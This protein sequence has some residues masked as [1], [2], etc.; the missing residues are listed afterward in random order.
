MTTRKLA[1]AE[2]RQPSR[3]AGAG[4]VAAP[5]HSL[6]RLLRLQRTVGNAAVAGLVAVQRGCGCGCG[7]VGGCTGPTTRRRRTAI[8]GCSG[9]RRTS[10]SRRPRVGPPPRRRHRCCRRGRTARRCA[11]C[12]STSTHL[13][14]TP[15]LEPDGAFGSLTQT[16]VKTFQSAHRLVPDGIV[17]P[18]T[19][20]MVRNERETEPVNFLVPCHTPE[21]P[22]PSGPKR[23]AGKEG[24]D[25]P[26]GGNLFGN[27][28]GREGEPDARA[29]RVPAGR[30]RG[31]SRRGQGPEGGLHRQDRES[32]Q[33]PPVH[34][35]PGDHLPRGV[36]RHGPH[37]H[38]Q[39]HPGQDHLVAGTATG[40]LH[41][42]DPVPR[43]QHR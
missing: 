41:R 17:G 28:G 39:R 12:R 30:G 4:R 5:S 25:Q 18:A 35:A 10:S 9:R 26:L 3:R 38:L 22:G 33:R 16:A 15:Q 29:H 11:N 31:R 19:S 32:A 40:R 7:G 37:R 6:P 20:T 43:L 21:R 8:W 13:G 34:R 2:A 24:V 42:S 23:E 14:A 27:P 36:R 1:R